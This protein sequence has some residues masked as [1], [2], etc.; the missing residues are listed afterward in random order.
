MYNFVKSH[1][2]FISKSD[3]K[4]INDLRMLGR[5]YPVWIRFGN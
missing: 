5:F 2:R 3:I 4:P 1:A